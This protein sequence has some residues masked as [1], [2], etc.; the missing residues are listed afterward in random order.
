MKILV[1]GGAGYIGSHVVK[2]L[3]KLGYE[4]LVLD[5]LSRGYKEAVLYGKLQILDLKYKNE[6]KKTISSFK[7]DAVMHFAA[8]IEVA[9]SVKYPVKYY[10]NNTAN[11]LNLIEVMLEEGVNNFIFSSTA[12]VYGEPEK[13]PIKEDFPLTPINPYGQ[14]KAFV[15]RISQDVDKANESFR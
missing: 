10:Q 9:E 15:E 8:F 14:S 1:T 12:A 2:Q 4:V 5:N 3:G 11:T 6:L 7:P 13:I